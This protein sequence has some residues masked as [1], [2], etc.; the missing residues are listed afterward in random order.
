MNLNNSTTYMHT[1]STHSRDEVMM[2]FLDSFIA[3]DSFVR[4]IDAY[5]SSLDPIQLE[6]KC[7]GKSSTGRPPYDTKV[8]I[9]LFLYGYLNSI[10][11][12]RKLER[13]CNRNIEL[14]WL[15][16]H[17][18]P[19]HSSISD[20][21]S[22]NT[23]GF[24]NLFK[25]FRNFCLQL[26]L[27]GKE[28]IAI[29]GTKIRA[30][31]SKK[32]NYNAK[33]IN[34]HLEYIE[35]Q[36]I[37]YIQSIEDHDL[38]DEKLKQLDKRKEKYEQLQKSLELTDETQ[39]SVTDPDSRALPLKMNIVQMSYNAQIATDSKYN[40]IAE[41]DATN[42][43]DAESLA[44]LAIK[45][46]QAFQSDSQE[47]VILTALADKGYDSAKEM[48]KCH[49]EDIDT[50]VAM[51]NPANSS[52][53]D[54]VKKE[55]FIYNKQKDIYT[56][57]Q[58]IVLERQGKVYERRVS[59]K[60]TYKFKRYVAPFSKCKDCPLL[61]E[62][63]TQAQQNNSHGRKI[64]RGYYQDARDRNKENMKKN[65]Q[66]YKKRQTMVEHP[67][68]TI[69]RQWGY[70]Y[71]LLKG[72]E[73]VKTEFSIIF[74]CYNLKRVSQIIGRIDLI[75]ALNK[76]NLGFSNFTATMQHHQLKTIIA[77]LHAA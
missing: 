54:K 15:L 27:Y 48:D 59:K 75:R 69:K 39:I 4:I 34:E 12:S 57:P 66:K 26:N 46:K 64:D 21:R 43:K 58:G 32:N 31:N 51:K 70:D 9:S 55:K 10:R 28:Y 17:L 42:E 37:D 25:H 6:F 50:L 2:V 3:E 44:N 65:K 47:P 40:L 72:L 52:K 45:S 16:N 71:T 13:E 68:G 33:K 18:K 8:F 24:K 23:K 11:S 77:C 73:K 53:S 74:L 60:K 35:N 19:K 56:C 67:F 41:Y 38:R 20:F 49:N 29:D 1:V 62:C 14:W 30:Q 22:Q 76:S 7:K 5:V 63:V 61:N 36:R